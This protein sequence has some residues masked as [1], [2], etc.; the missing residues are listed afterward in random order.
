MFAILDFNLIFPTLPVF[1]ILF[2]I[3]SEKGF[4]DSYKDDSNPANINLNFI[5][6][7]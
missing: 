7:G 3:R 5:S 2:E 1:R 6:F 4:T